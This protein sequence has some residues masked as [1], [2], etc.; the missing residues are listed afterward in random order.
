MQDSHSL[1]SRF[2]SL[3]GLVLMLG[4]LLVIVGPG[5]LWT[6]WLN[7]QMFRVGTL[8]LPRPEAEPINNIRLIQL[9]ANGLFFC[10]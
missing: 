3:S 4:F 10:L 9:P 7:N 6:D 8:L 5:L 2:K 1:I